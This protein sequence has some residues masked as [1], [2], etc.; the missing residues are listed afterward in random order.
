M[1]TKTIR[2]VLEDYDGTTA[3]YALVFAESAATPL[4]STGDTV[5]FSSYN[6]F[7]FDWTEAISGGVY[8]VQLYKVSDNTVVSA[9]GKVY[10][11][12]DIAGTYYIDSVAELNRQAF[13]NQVFPQVIRD[14]SD[15]NVI[16]FY[17]PL[18]SA[19]VT[20]TKVINGGTSAAISGAINYV[21]TLGTFYEYSLAYNASDRPTASGVV[22]YTLTD[23][24]NT[25]FMSLQLITGI[26]AAQ[27]AQLDLLGTAGATLTRPVTAT[28]YIDEIIIGD[29]YLAS[30][31]TAFEWSWV[32][33]DGFVAGTSTC[34]FGGVSQCDGTQGWLVTGTITDTAGTWTLSF[35]LPKAVTSLLSGKY[36]W[37]VEVTNASSNEVTVMKSRTQRPAIAVAKQT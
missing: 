7:T 36:D 3:L 5:T 31:D 26:T 6:S 25:R 24:T 37:S 18:P 15:Q 32:A 12:A 13:T 8:D 2:G 10:V 11:P 16:N 23:G 4:N 19:T 1:A 20:G 28:G 30:T 9:R 29:D 34:R 33:H 22:R 21:G 14:V 17:W 27:A 35:D